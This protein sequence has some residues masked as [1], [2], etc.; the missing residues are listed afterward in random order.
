MV[1]F[2][3]RRMKQAVHLRTIP[4]VPHRVKQ[5]FDPPEPVDGEV[6]DVDT[7]YAN[8]VVVTV[9]REGDRY[10]ETYELA[11]VE[12]ATPARSHER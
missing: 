5:L 10:H 8:A 1:T 11:D 4:A 2:D 12:P 3:P 9:E 7:G 6:V